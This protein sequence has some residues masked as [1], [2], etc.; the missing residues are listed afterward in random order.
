MFKNMNSLFADNISS[1]SVSISTVI[2]NGIKTTRKVT[3][4]NG[5]K[6]VEEYEEPYEGDRNTLL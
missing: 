3:I 6:K 2:E 4:E 1:H 5:V